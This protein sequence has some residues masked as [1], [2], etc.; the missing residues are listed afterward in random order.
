MKRHVTAVVVLALSI[1]T[2]LA[3]TGEVFAA[4]RCKV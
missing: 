3:L 4:M 1:A 2:F